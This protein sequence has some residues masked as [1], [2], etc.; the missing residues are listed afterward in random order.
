MLSTPTVSTSGGRREEGVS[1]A[2][3]NAAHSAEHACLHMD[4]PAH[5]WK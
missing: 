1:A 2:C 3:W 5:H 4:V